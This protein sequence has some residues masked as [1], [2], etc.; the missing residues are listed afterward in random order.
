MKAEYSFS[1]RQRRLYYDF[2]THPPPHHI[3][4]DTP[5][6]YKKEELKASHRRGHVVSCTF[7]TIGDETDE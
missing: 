6:I 2:E 5:Q 7:K 4:K 3:E 1:G